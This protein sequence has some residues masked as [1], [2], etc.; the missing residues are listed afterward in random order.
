MEGLKLK[1]KLSSERGSRK[2]ADLCRRAKRRCHR[3]V[4]S[5]WKSSSRNSAYGS[6][7]ASA[8]CSRTSRLLS[9]P[10]RRNFLRCCLR[11]L[12]I[13][14]VNEIGLGF[15]IADQRMVLSKAKLGSVLRR[16]GPCFSRV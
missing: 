8:S 10:E 7:L 4:V 16:V 14:L 5:S 3:R 11:V 2:S 12:V 6:R 1:S 13:V 15:D 9:S